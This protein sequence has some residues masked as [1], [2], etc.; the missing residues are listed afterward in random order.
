MI[1]GLPEF[2]TLDIEYNGL[3]P[4]IAASELRGG[5]WLNLASRI[6][7]P[8]VFL[9]VNVKIDKN[10]IKNYQLHHLGSGDRLRFAYD[11]PPLDGGTSIDKIE[12]HDRAAPGMSLNKGSRL[13][14]DVNGGGVQKRIVPPEGG[15]FN[16]MLANV[17]I[18]HARVWVTA[19]N[20]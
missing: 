7:L 14:I 17:P 20:D 3:G 1:E 8:V 15:G 12:E 4:F 6:D 5:I 18:D 10:T 2:H 9:S 11:S 19:G 13:G 16:L